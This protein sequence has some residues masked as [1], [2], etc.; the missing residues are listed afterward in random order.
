M[1]TDRYCFIET[2]KN[3]FNFEKGNGFYADELVYDKKEKALFQ[4]TV[5]NDDYMEKRTVAITAKPINREIEDVTTLHAPRLV[6][7]YKEGLLKEGKLKEIASRLDEEDN[8][9]IMLVKQKK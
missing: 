5:Y 6:E 3:V 1:C 2:V 7:N 4:V 8:A 9:V